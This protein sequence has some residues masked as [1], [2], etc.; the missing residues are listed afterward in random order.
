MRRAVYIYKNIYSPIFM[1]KIVFGIALI[2][3]AFGSSNI[4]IAQTPV[5]VEEPLS[6][7]EE[8]PEF[9]GGQGKMIDF[10]AKNIVYPSSA[11]SANKQGIVYVKFIVEKDGKLDNFQ[12][13][14]GVSPEL[15]STA[16]KAVKEMP[17]WKP[18]KQDG[19]YVRIFVVVPVSFS[20]EGDN[21]KKKK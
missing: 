14:R 12:V 2:L 11:I 1:K 20:L 15:D 8:M 13:V 4:L 17:Q 5:D 19:K 16:L 10:L 7:V 9:P 21:P 3:F 18:G 6:I